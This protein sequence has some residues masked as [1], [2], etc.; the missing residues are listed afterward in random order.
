MIT[1]TPDRSSVAVCNVYSQLSVFGSQKELPALTKMDCHP[2]P[3][4]NA[5]AERPWLPM[6]S[7][8]STDVESILASCDEITA[9]ACEDALPNSG[10]DATG[11]HPEPVQR[12][13][14]SPFAPQPT[15][16]ASPVS[17]IIP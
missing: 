11:V 16:A 15:T 2:V 12:N 6:T 5:K 13:V 8:L 7:S 10:L 3:D 17:S 4:T 9:P 1:G 14:E